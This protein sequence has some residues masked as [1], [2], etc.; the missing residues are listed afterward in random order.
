M[1]PLQVAQRRLSLAATPRER[2]VY[3][4]AVRAFQA[5]T[6]APT[7]ATGSAPDDGGAAALSSLQ[8]RAGVTAARSKRERVKTG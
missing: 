6:A 8:E 5:L 3:G 2:V 4:L 1:T 7:V